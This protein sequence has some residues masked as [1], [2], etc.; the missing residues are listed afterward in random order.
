MVLKGKH[1]PRN[2]S[3]V[4]RWIEFLLGSWAS[5]TWL[6]ANP[7]AMCATRLEGENTSLAAVWTFRKWN[8]SVFYAEETPTFFYFW[9]QSSDVN[10]V[11]VNSV[12]LRSSR[13]RLRK[14]P[15]ALGDRKYK[16]LQER[17]IIIESL[18]S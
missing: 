15:R 11:K 6:R 13:F 10:E 4:L 9:S 1:E 16:K 2:V 18:C 7:L 12:C 5:G 8:N 3:C 14:L 17:N